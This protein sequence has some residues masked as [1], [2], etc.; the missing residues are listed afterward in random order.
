MSKAISKLEK[1]LQAIN[2]YVQNNTRTIKTITK[3]FLVSSLVGQTTCFN[4]LSESFIKVIIYKC[5]SKI[6]NVA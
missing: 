5:L 6:K 2:K 1:I 4:S 3:Y